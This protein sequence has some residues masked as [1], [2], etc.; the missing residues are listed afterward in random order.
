[1]LTL[2]F[3]IQPAKAEP[4]T[5]IVDDD[6]P[7][8]FHTIQEAINAAN[9][10]DTIYVKA[11]TYFEEIMVN[12][13]L[14]IQGEKGLTWVNGSHFAYLTAFTVSANFVEIDNFNIWG[15]REGI[16]IE[17]SRNCSI[18]D[19]YMMEMDLYGI[20][21]NHSNYTKLFNNTI[22]ES[23]GGISLEYSHGNILRNNSIN[24]YNQPLPFNKL[25][26]NFGVVGESLDQYINDVDISNTIHG[27]PIYYL[28]NEKNSEI[29]PNAGYILV[30][31]SSNVIVRNQNITENMC[32]VQFAYTKN[33][34]IQNIGADY[35][36]HGIY[37]Y[38]SDN[39]TIEYANMKKNFWCGIFLSNSSFNKINNNYIN[40]NDE[41]ILIADGSANN[42]LRNNIMV[43]NTY[44]F[45]IEW[46]N[47]NYRQDIDTSNL[48]NG[49]PIYYL[50]D[51]QNEII[52]SNA[53]FVAIVNSTKITLQNLTISNNLI[54][55]LLAESSNCVI[56]NVTIFNCSQYDAGLAIVLSSQ[57]LVENS[58][59]K[60]P[61]LIWSGYQNIIRRNLV[62]QSRCGIEL[63][64]TRENKI[65]QNNIE[66][67]GYGISL[68]WSTQNIIY[69]NNFLYNQRNIYLESSYNN[70]WD[71]GYPS[72]GNYWSNYNSSDVYNGP[73]QNQI[74][75]DG[76][77]DTP[78]VID[79]NN[80]DRYPAIAPI[81]IFDAFFVGQ[82]MLSITII[83]NST[84]SAFHFDPKDGPFLRFNL[85]GEN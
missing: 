61:I 49:K 45:G 66:N 5:W 2:A 59:I 77:C 53:G 4:R 82:S 37:L 68:Y 55:V 75:S 13:T 84:V 39:N 50:L 71:D 34:C 21:L 79:A 1:M 24:C 52:P 74:G 26:E 47:G 36:W 58:T 35:N 6:G 81:T 57:N 14:L 12:K 56:R 10:G 62:Y 63:Q 25:I 33:S 44:N 85:T 18:N 15:F 80:I 17:N 19:I 78:Y 73:D 67:N 70:F 46:S 76:I 65:F 31:N 29:P 7:A 20:V 30:V 83:T 60:N 9:D 54:G 64:S 51:T 3:N 42:V 69:S 48:V 40:N 22:I 27:K 23:Y 41:G 43:N 38:N 32:G 16:R 72:A 11:G 8:D 28:I